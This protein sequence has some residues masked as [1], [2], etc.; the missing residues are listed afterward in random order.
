MTGSQIDVSPIQVK[1]SELDR[2]SSNS[3]YRSECPVCKIGI[4]LVR[5]DDDSFVL[6]AE[7]RCILCGQKFVYDDIDEMRKKDFR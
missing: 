3:I 4:L 1:H 5:R 6:K 2:D 7:D